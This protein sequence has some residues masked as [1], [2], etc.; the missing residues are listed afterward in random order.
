MFRLLF[1]KERYTV[2]PGQVRASSETLKDYSSFLQYEGSPQL[3]S[4]KSHVHQANRA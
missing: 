4:R 3:A 1:N 2:P